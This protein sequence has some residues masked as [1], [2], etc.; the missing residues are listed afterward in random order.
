MCMVDTGD[1]VTFFASCFAKSYVGAFF[2]LILG[3]MGM[4][5]LCRFTVACRFWAVGFMFLSEKLT[6]AQLRKK[7]LRILWNPNVHYSV[8]KVPLLVPILSL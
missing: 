1:C 6:V 2:Q 5:G 4:F 3:L 7:L 8:L